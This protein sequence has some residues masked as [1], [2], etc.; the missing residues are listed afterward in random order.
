MRVVFCEPALSLL[1]FVVLF[2]ISLT[3]T[4]CAFSSRYFSSFCFIASSLLPF[5]HVE[6][7]L[8]FYFL[9]SSCHILGLSPF[10]S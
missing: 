1:V 4:V 10:S 3:V 8:I 6:I 9:F 2:H 5:L 7:S